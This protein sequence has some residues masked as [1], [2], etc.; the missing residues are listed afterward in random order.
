VSSE[1]QLEARLVR[2]L[3][4]ADH[5]EPS[6]DLWSRVVHSIEEDRQHRRRVAHTS[7]GAGVIAAA[8]VLAGALALTDG[9]SGTVVR[10]QVME[11]LETIALVGLIVALGPGIRRFGR[12]YAGDLFTAN[13]STS[14][15]LLRLLDLAFSLVFAGFVVATIEPLSPLEV[16]RLTLAA[17]LGDA[18]ERIGLL[19]VAMGVLHAITLVAI[20][21]LALIVNST[22]TARAVPRWIWIG[23]AVAS[24]QLVGLLFL[25]ATIVFR[26]R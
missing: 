9:P 20:P 4:H 13:R 3:G 14:A 25:F 15:S 10:W 16:S 24:W 8:L 6:P 11:I 1:Q 22:R 26:T 19:L 7:V 21:L 18:A 12:G 5:V 17:Q 23:I 2:A